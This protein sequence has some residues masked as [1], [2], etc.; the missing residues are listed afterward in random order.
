MTVQCHFCYYSPLHSLSLVLL[1][2]TVPVAGF[3][4]S[5]DMSRG[6]LLF[7]SAVFIEVSES[8][9]WSLSL[10]HCVFK[11]SSVPFSLAPTPGT[12]T[13]CML[14]ILIWSLRSQRLS[15][16]T[17]IHSLLVFQFGKHLLNGLQVH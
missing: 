17:F 8:V 6:A 16:F 10:G 4:H 9:D 1:L 11:W 7:H 12:P 3:P 13:L 15:H 5:D 14:D 2:K